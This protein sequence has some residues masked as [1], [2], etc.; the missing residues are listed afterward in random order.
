MPK[1]K[2]LIKGHIKPKVRRLWTIRPAV[3]THSTRKG[4][5]GYDR[6]T[7]KKIEREELMYGSK[8]DL[9]EAR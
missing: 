8:Q 3:K 4:A 2:E 9:S 7:Q 6:K 5:K 1:E